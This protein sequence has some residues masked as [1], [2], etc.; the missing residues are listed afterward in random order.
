M[1]ENETLVELSEVEDEWYQNWYRCLGCGC[2]FMADDPKYCPSCGKK[3]TGYRIEGKE[4]VY[5]GKG[6]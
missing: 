4:T 1:K 6:G 3:I 2:A 5:Y